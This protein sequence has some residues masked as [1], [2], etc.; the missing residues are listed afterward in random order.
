[1]MKEKI[2]CVGERF[3]LTTESRRIYLRER[4][5]FEQRTLMISEAQRKIQQTEVLPEIGRN[6]VEEQEAGQEQ[7]PEEE[8][9]LLQEQSLEVEQEA[10]EER[11]P[12][13]ELGL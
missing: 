1:M 12:E 13:E 3:L 4:R 5:Q 6:L 11:I 10:V 7:N 8:L 9:E 2:L